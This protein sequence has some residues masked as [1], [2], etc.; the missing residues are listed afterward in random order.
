MIF[1]CPRPEGAQKETQGKAWPSPHGFLGRL[2]VATVQSKGRERWGARKKEIEQVWDQCLGKNSGY[3]YSHVGVELTRSQWSEVDYVSVEPELSKKLWPENHLITHNGMLFNHKKGIEYDIC[4]NVDEPWQCYASEGSQ[5]QRPR[6]V[7]APLYEMCRVVRS[8]Q[9]ESTLWLP[10]QVCVAPA[11]WLS[12]NKFL[13]GN[14][15]LIEC[16]EF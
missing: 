3:D 1:E 5:T 16:M 2:T 12:P 15:L 8:T 10:G 4:Y 7:W 11:K 13:R 9:T 6:V 14:S